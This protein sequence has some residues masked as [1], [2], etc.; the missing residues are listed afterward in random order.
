MIQYSLHDPLYL[1]NLLFVNHKIPSIL[2]LSECSGNG[3][4]HVALSNGVFFFCSPTPG[5]TRRKSKVG[6]LPVHYAPSMVLLPY[7]N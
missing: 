5:G 4:S 6:F 2:N 7:P 3:D 1:W